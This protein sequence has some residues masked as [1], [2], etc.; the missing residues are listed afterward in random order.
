[1]H[2]AL[3]GLLESQ[4]PVGLAT[5]RSWWDQLADR[6]ID[7]A[8]V[9]ALLASLTSR[10]PDHQ[11]L[12]HLL[13]S[14]TERRPAPAATTP[15]EGTVNVVG[16]GGG[17]RTFNISTASAFVA[18]A[19]GV[20]VVKTG[21]RAYTSSL[22][23]V[24]LLERLG[25][26]L[27]SSH[28]HTEDTLAAHGIA[29]AGPYVYPPQLT[30]LARTAA[31]HG[32]KPFGRFLNALGPFLADLPVTAQV[33]GVSATAPLD[34]LRALAATT[35]TR[36]IWLVSND[37][38]ADELLPFATNTVHEDTTRTRTIRP[39][40]LTPGD[41][42]FGDLRPADPADA[43]AHFRSV[44]SGTAGRVATRTVCLGAA[45]LLVASGTRRD[46]PSAVAVAEAAVRSGAAHDLAL[47]LAAPAAP[48]PLA[49][50]HA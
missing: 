21:S 17:P 47:R 27:T 36:R 41:G 8:Q 31:P 13:D 29:F 6:Q 9:L 28:A 19:A 23:S 15:W 45:A 18:A 44:L 37:T 40:E 24:D 50:A 11:T 16:T 2:D 48:R 10:L 20:K 42:S 38:G 33:T 3:T 1:M 46:W 14:L 25:I 26:R 30:R 7:Q 49:V 22:G 34:T 32:M 43:P 39:G 5:W 4:A 35:T 12:R